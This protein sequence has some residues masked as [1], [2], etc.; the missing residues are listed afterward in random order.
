MD[1]RLRAAALRLRSQLTAG[2]APPSACR[3][4]LASVPFAERDAWID[5]VLGLGGLPEDGR[6]PAGCVPYLPC[7]VDA[8][9]RAGQLLELQPADTFV[10]VG[11]GVGRA[12]LVVHLMF[13]VAALGV[14]I[15]PRLVQE[16]REVMAR[17]AVRDI[18]IVLGDAVERTEALERGSVFFLYCPFSGARLH[19]LLACIERIAC[20]RRVRICS[21]DIPIPPLDWLSTSFDDGTLAIHHSRR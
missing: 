10:D 1:D 9:M 4:A 21:V 18:P 3:A 8:L 6:L 16:A 12:A 17:L 5:S 7:P 11:A 13:G 20:S 14:E 15:Q 19:K 2:Q